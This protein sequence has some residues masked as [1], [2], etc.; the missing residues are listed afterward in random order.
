MDSFSSWMF[1]LWQVA[2]HPC[3]YFFVAGTLFGMLAIQMGY[4]WGKSKKGEGKKEEEKKVEG[5]KGKG[6]KQE[7][8]V[9][10]KKV[11]REEG[12]DEDWE[13]FSAP[14]SVDQGFSP[15]PSLSLSI[16]LRFHSVI[17]L[18]FFLLLLGEHIP[19]AYTKRDNEEMKKRSEVLSLSLF[20]SFSPP[21]LD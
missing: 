16:F 17:H 9:R 1:F 6:K 19:L 14:K 4:E 10:R 20:L 3:T 13:E 21:L 11:W 5:K 15:F 7:K 8:E 12:D 2:F 18:P